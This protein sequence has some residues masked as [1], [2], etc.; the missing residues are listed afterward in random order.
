MFGTEIR[1]GSDKHRRPSSPRGPPRVHHLVATWSPGAAAPGSLVALPVTPC[2][3]PLIPLGSL[4]I[5]NPSGTGWA[6]LGARR[7]TG[8]ALRGEAGRVCLRCCVR[9]CLPLFFFCWPSPGHRRALTG[10]PGCASR[11]LPGTAH[12]GTTGTPPGHRLGTA[13]NTQADR[14]SASGSV[15]LDALL[16]LGDSCTHAPHGAVPNRRAGWTS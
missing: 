9:V 4:R 5:L 16:R 3:N 6:P 13:G 1:G 8:W 11:A 14:S 2:A 10:S 7:V 12:Q 15:P